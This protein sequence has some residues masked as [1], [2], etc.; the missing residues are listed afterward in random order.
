L[1]YGLISAAASVEERRMIRALAILLLCQL[2]GTVLQEALGLPVP[3]P[4]IGFVL[5]A[6]IFLYTK[7]PGAE[8][9]DT[10]Q[11]LL[12]H[13]G[14]LFV[15]AGV[16]VVGTLGVLKQ[17]ALALVIAIPVSTVLGLLVTGVIMQWFM[18]RQDQA[19]A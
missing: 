8:L 17:N 6:A 4:V 7:G 16:G 1:K 5:L 3:G 11:G 18:R 19:D 14:L 13:M 12:K 10:A 15:P 9:H 2:V